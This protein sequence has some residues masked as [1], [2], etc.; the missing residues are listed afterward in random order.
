M[1]STVFSRLTLVHAV[2]FVSEDLVRK[3]SENL[4]GCIDPVALISEEGSRA[5]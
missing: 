3:N 4:Q 2:L 1:Q 5:C